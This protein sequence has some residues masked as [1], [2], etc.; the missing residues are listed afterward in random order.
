MAALGEDFHQ[1][2][3]RIAPRKV[4]TVDGVLERVALVDGNCLRNAVGLRLVNVVG[5]RLV[6][7]LGLNGLRL[8]NVSGQRRVSMGG[9][10][11]F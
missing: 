10:R 9:L 11:P 2:G 3:C 1:L 8:V 6:S 5:L 7:L 4:D